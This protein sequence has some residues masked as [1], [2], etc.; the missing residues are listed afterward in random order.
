VRTG[1]G[2]VTADRVT[3]TDIRGEQMG[4]RPC[5]RRSRDRS[6]ILQARE[7][8]APLYP[9]IAADVRHMGSD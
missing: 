7:K 8:V 4:W 9:R 3:T 6:A 5:I 1:S 2:L